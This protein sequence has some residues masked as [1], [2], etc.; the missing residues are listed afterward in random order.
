MK[1]LISLILFVGLLVGCDTA[2]SDNGELDGMWYLTKVDTLSNGHFADYRSKR[3]FWSFQG[4][5]AQFTYGD[6]E[7]HYYMS[8]FDHKASRLKLSGLFF[9]NRSKGD[10]ILDSETL[11]E[12]RPFGINNLSNEY[13]VKRLDENKM[14]LQDDVLCLHFE[15][16]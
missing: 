16:Y 6:G 14:I 12:I 8:R 15:K 1:N 7:N 11:D 4:T 5:L 2:S 9:Y 10:R 3:V 13:V